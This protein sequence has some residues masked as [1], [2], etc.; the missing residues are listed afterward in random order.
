[1]TIYTGKRPSIRLHGNELRSRSQ[2][3]RVRYNTEGERKR[4]LAVTIASRSSALVA[5][6]RRRS[7]P[8]YYSLQKPIARHRSH[9]CRY[10]YKQTTV[11]ADFSRRSPVVPEIRP[12]RTRR[13]SKRDHGRSSVVRPTSTARAS[14]V[15][16]SVRLTRQQ[17]VSARPDGDYTPYP[18]KETQ[19]S[20]L[21]TRRD[22]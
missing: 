20:L 9:S 22:V 16:T 6:R 21:R 15:F 3:R 2:R 8:H 7:S 5:R 17:R 19:R 12:N 13:R 4:H 1:M 11:V 10:A 14:A 18:E